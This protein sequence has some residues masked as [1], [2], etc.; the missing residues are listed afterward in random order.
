MGE[1]EVRNALSEL[2]IAIY[3]GDRPPFLLGLGEKKKMG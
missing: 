2:H 1:R 3:K